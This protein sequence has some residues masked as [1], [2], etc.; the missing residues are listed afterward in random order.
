MTFLIVEDEPLAVDKISYLLKKADSES[1]ILGVTGSIHETVNWLNNHPNPDI[2]L[3]DIELSDG[4]SFEIFEKVEIKSLVIFTTSYDEYALKAFKVNSIDYLLKPIQL[5]DLKA[6]INKYLNLTKGNTTNGITNLT[7]LLDQIQ[8]TIQIPSYRERFLVRQGNKHFAIE[9]NKIAYLFVEERIVFIKTIENK[10]HI[11]EYS[12]D[13]IE[14]QLDPK[15]FF[16]ANR[17]FIVCINSVVQIHDY[18]NSRLVISLSPE[19]SKEVIVSRDRVNDFKQ[20]VGK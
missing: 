4:Q 12:L 2:I 10:K 20:W 3:M 7:K 5:E 1:E 13:E 18:L 16:R 19:F 11:L 6:S 15:N 9:I 8:H 17:S 14:M